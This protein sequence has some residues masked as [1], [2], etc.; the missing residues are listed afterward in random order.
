M[1]PYWEL[2]SK[3]VLW[4]QT[5]ELYVC[6]CIS[7][8]MIFIKNKKSQGQ[9]VKTKSDQFSDDNEQILPGSACDRRR[10]NTMFLFEIF[11]AP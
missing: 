5:F 3:H 6:K 7:F 1:E 8:T 9:L 2:L 4:S 10:M 11:M